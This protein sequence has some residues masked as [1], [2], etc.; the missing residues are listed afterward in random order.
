MAQILY[1]KFTE[2]RGPGYWLQIGN[3]IASRR[4]FRPDHSNAWRYA[5]GA[6]ESEIRSVSF[7]ALLPPEK[8]TSRRGFRFVILADTGEGDKSQYGLL[9]L[10]RH[11]R[12][13]FMILVGDLANPAGRISS[14]NDRKTDDYLAGFFEPY[15][16][17]NVPIWSVPG[18]H[19]YYAEGQGREYYDTFCT[20]KYAGRWAEY[21]L[22]IVP[23]PGTYWELKD[24]GS[25]LIVIGVDTG[26]AGRL[27]GGRGEPADGRQYRWLEDRLTLT[28]REGKSVLLVFHIPVLDGQKKDK[29]P[30]LDGLYRIVSGHRSVRWVVCGHTHN[31]QEYGPEMFAEFLRREMRVSVP[32]ARAYHLINGG[33]GSTL[34]HTDYESRPRERRYLA[35]RCFPTSGQWAGEYAVYDPTIVE[36]LDAKR[37]IW[38]RILGS[39][40]RRG[41][42]VVKPNILYDADRPKFL[43]FLLVDVQSE[44]GAEQKVSI[45]PVFMED[46]ERLFAH[47]PEGTVD[48]A[49]PNPPA[50][51]DEVCRCLQSELFL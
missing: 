2:D 19:E 51:P 44:E 50:N 42:A 20:R 13:D 30:R 35:R 49:D 38:G 16:N 21:G 25:P 7:A 5:F 10:L 29:K 45:R 34:D 17:F 3:L 23:Q 28:D 9:P 48:I 15:R 8:D 27:D 47:L 36:E 32:V 6:P 31:Y 11:L 22:R 14:E 1:P 43:S 4:S 24:E 37:G 18:N 12:P 40:L 46:V 39:L 26:K 41:A 33:G